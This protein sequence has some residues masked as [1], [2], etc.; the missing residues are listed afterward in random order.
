LTPR[1]FNWAI[2]SDRVT[3]IVF[4][5]TGTPHCVRTA[6]LFSLAKTTE[7]CTF[8]MAAEGRHKFPSILGTA[9][10]ERHKS[11]LSL[12]LNLCSIGGG[13]SPSPTCMTSS[14]GLSEETLGL[15]EAYGVGFQLLSVHSC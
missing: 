9:G 1:D 15:T 4:C 13:T 6:L 10:E 7:E 2:N 8:S 5:S 14:T 3:A 11:L 12:A